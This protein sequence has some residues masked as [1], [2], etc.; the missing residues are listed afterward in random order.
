M[1]YVR[2]I[3]LALEASFS[4][5]TTALFTCEDMEAAF[6]DLSKLNACRLRPVGAELTVHS[7]SIGE[8]DGLP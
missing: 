8:K 7:V 6:G 5:G 4:D 2:D 3:G 1:R